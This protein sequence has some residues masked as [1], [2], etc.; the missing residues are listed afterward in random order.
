MTERR[1][2]AEEI[3]DLRDNWHQRT[4]SGWCRHFNI[5]LSTME[6]VIAKMRGI[7]PECCPEV[8]DSRLSFE[9]AL[10]ALIVEETT[11]AE[12]ENH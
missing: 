12:A 5:A 2:T 8:K 7:W 11:G 1:W 6:D 9:A 10:A 4:K 3:R